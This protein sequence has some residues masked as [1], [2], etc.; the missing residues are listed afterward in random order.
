MREHY[1]RTAEQ[2]R[3]FAAN[4]AEVIQRWGEEL[5]R[6]WGLYLTGGTRSFAA[7]RMGVEQ[8]ELQGTDGTSAW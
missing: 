7:C 4:R 8:F 6:V 5:A 2:W 3:R 1:A